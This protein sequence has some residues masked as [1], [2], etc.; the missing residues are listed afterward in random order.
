MNTISRIALAFTL[1]ASSV[2]SAQLSVH[3]RLER[4]QY[5][6]FEPVHAYVTITNRSGQEL[7]LQSRG[8]D[9]ITLSWLDFRVRDSSGTELSRLT[10][11]V[12]R[13][14]KIPAG[15][16]V[17]RKVNLSG[18]FGLTRA[19]SYSV[20]ALVREGDVQAPTVYQSARARF[21]VHNGGKLFTQ[22]FG[23]PGTPYP[24]REYQ[25]LRFNDGE[26]T[27]IY[28]S[29]LNKANNSSISTFRLSK[30]LFFT[31]PRIA[32]DRKNQL[33][34]LYLANPS[35]FVHAIVNRDG[36]MTGTKYYKRGATGA[37]TLA[38]FASGDIKVRG[39][40]HYDPKKEA[41]IRDQSRR[42]TER[43]K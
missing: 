19:N 33:H 6:K 14:V 43:P 25:V 20:M 1:I 17:V 21:A 39:G 36:K 5:L 32:L 11:A 7:T 2:A 15:R 35:V 30:A 34:I 26:S 42:I 27:S 8:R 40:I 31:K 37:P 29:V 9:N 10:N 18:L 13:A 41:A 22:P 24:K 38:R 28:A 12:F 4:K 3:L 23:A 16:S